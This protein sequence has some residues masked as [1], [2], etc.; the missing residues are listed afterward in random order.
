MKRVLTWLFSAFVAILFMVLV[1][2][3]IEQAVVRR[4]TAAARTAITGPIAVEVAAVTAHDLSGTIVVTGTLRSVDLVDVVA[5]VPGRVETLPV[6]VGARV[7]K[8]DVLA[9]LDD[10]DSQLGL[11]QAEGM[12]AAATAS[13]DAAAHDAASAE[14]LAAADAMTETQLVAARSR[15]AAAEGQLAQAKAGRDLAR[16]HVRDARVTSPIDGI[17]TKRALA[18]GQMVA[19]GAPILQVQD[20]AHYQVDIALDEAS[21]YAVAPGTEATITSVARVGEPLVGTVATVSST[22]DPMTRKAAAVIRVDSSSPLITNATVSV[23]IP[24]GSRPGALAVPAT[25]IG[26]SHDAPVVRV[27]TANVVK[28]VPVTV[29]LRDGDLV[30]IAGVDAGSFVVTAGPVDIPDGAV[31]KV[32]N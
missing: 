10:T 22:L 4:S 1:L 7:Q 13:R 3:R 14:K 20:D 2:W 28:N 30:E 11:A 16:E 24:V 25:A 21:A 6:D 27:V 15:L 29:G 19:P 5:D 8:G 12:V 9:T 32:G 17:V 31:V 18:I 23:R 26:E